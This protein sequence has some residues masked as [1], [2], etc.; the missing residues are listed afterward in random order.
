[1]LDA[2][3]AKGLF[4]DPI[5]RMGVRTLFRRRLQDEEK[6]DGE[7]NDQKRLEFLQ[8]LRNSPIALETDK[9]NDQHY[10]VPTEF[11]NYVLGTEMKYSCS[12]WTPEM[13][14]QRDL[15]L[16]EKKMLEMTL[17]R[18]EL[19]EGQTI[20][21]LGCG[22]GAITLAMARKYPMNT[23]TAVSNSE[24]QKAHIEKRLEAE[25]L[26][27]V[28]VLTTNV[29]VLE[30]PA[31]KYDRVVS[32]EMFEHVRNYELLL[33]RISRWLKPDG[34]LFVHIFVHKEQAYKYESKDETDWMSRYF[35]SGGTMPSEHLLYYFQ[36]DMKVE[37]HWRVN[38]TH[39]GLTS[40]AWLHRMDSYK[41]EIMEIFSKHYG[42][43]QALKWWHY[44]RLFFL[45]CE[46]FFSYRNG[47]EWYVCHYLLGQACRV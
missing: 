32:V 31:Q 2:M 37:Q 12:Y 38:G 25:G 19:A 39:Y 17:E 35:F 41:K 9:A 34:K 18:A 16:A 4:P 29:A 13:N 23:I 6:V 11:F 22:W 45:T 8:E 33:S 14:V 30:Q 40:K 27:N 5:L 47:K 1:M 43:E 21:E 7:A 20:L 24:T 28:T 46:E 44:W 10:R 15:G 36:N 26:T 42:Q 3:L